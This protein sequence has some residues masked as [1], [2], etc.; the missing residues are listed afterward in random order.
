MKHLVL[1]LPVLVG[2]APVKEIKTEEIEYKH[3]DT[4]LQGFVAYDGAKEGRRPGVIVVHE[5]KGHGDYV[6]RRARMLAEMGYVAFAVD[7]YGKGVFAKDHEE[8]ARLSGAFFKDRGLMRD[9]AKAGYDVLAKHSMCDASKMAAIGYCFGGTTVLEMARAG[10]DVK[11]VG[12][13]HGN[14]TAPTPAE[15]DKVKAIVAVFHGADDKFVGDPEAFKK[16]MK[17]AGVDVRFHAF[18]GTVHSFTVK[19]AGDDVSTGMAYN[20]KADTE[21]WKLLSKYLDE[22]FGK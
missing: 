9:R 12:S 13:F 2:A 22:A 7:M 11:L 16:E 8:A 19:E 15:K 5:W 21:S 1:L 10:L 6:R 4:V 17:D 14:L 20:E 18:E 3:G